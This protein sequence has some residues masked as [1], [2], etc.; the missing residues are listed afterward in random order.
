M[1]LSG[2][3]SIP[4]QES[5]DM[6]PVLDFIDRIRQR[7][8]TVVVGQDVV[9]ERLLI[10]L[11]TG[12]HTLLQGVPGLAKTLLVSA[13]AKSIHLEFSRIQFTVDLLPSDIVGSEILDQKSNDFRVHKGPI[14]TNLLL[15]DEINRA[16]PKVQSALLEAMQEHKVTIGN[17]TFKLP[18]PFLVIATQNPVEQAGTFELPEA[19]LDRFMLCHRLQYPTPAEE[20]EVLLRNARL[21]IRREGDGA[22]A[23]T[24]FDV[25]EQ[26]AVG[27]AEDLIA[28]MNAVQQVYVSETF[29]D[30]VIDIVH[31]TRLDSRLDFG[32][33]PRAGI[34]LIKAA[35]AR[36]IIHRRHYV[37]PEDLYALAEDIILHRIRLNYEALADGQTG[38]Q[39]LQQI[40]TE[41]GGNPITNGKPAMA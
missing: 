41:A 7:I 5:P 10:S 23:R 6:T 24:E 26:E 12:G 21:G 18:A 15:A 33:S 16:A 9:V 22:V 40:M 17:E 4:H 31:R 13:L 2:E 19:Q 30:H 36:A 28:A 39:I 25:L 11:F 32:C 34:A 35:R 38:P 3:P 29:T 20:R 37:I 14:F 1:S 27:S 8:S